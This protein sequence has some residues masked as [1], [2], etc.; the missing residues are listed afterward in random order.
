LP[1][2]VHALSCAGLSESFVDGT[3]ALLDSLTVFRKA[4][5]GR[6]SYKQEDL[7]CDILNKFMG[8]TMLQKMCVL[9]PMLFR[10]F[11]FISLIELRQQNTVLRVLVVRAV[12]KNMLFNEEKA[13]NIPSLSVLIDNAIPSAKHIAGSGLNMQHIETMCVMNILL[14][15]IRKYVN[16]Y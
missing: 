12:D 13:K 5:P 2:L 3:K 11:P 8:H 15:L 1:V 6:K 4:I 14:M 10:I 7:V 9:W 16:M